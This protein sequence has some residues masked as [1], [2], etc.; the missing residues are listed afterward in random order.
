[1]INIDNTPPKLYLELPLDGSKTSKQVFLGG[2]TTDNI[3]LRDL[4]IT[5]R[6]LDGKS[7]PDRLA[8]RKL[9]PGEI[10]SQVIDI[11]DLSN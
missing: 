9:V 4:N 7:V 2:Q 11:S 8:K 10:I 5:I 1:M 6:S 3:G